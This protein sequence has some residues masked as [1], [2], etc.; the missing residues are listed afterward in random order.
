MNGMP[1]KNYDEFKE[2]FVREDGKRK[3]KV[4]LD[5][6]KSR[7]V[8]SFIVNRGYSSQFCA[9]TSMAQLKAYVSQLIRATRHF[10]PIV[11]IMGDPY[12]TPEFES[13]GN[14]GICED[15][16]FTCYRYY[17][18]TRGGVYKMRIGKLFRIAMLNSDFGRVLPE[19]IIL[20]M[21]EEISRDWI[22]YAQ[23]RLPGY[24]LVVDDDFEAIYNRDMYENRADFQSCMTSQEQHYFYE[25]SVDAKAA[26]I[27]NPET[28]NIL[29][30][31]VIYMDARDHA[32][33]KYRLAERQYSKYGDEVLKS[34]LVYA[35]I[36]GGYIDGYK[37]VGADCHNAKAWL[38][39]THKPI[40]NNEF[41]I[42][43]NLE[44]DDILS[45]QDSFKWYDRNT[46]TAYNYAY[47]A[48]THMLDTTDSR[49]EGENYDSWHEEYT[50]CD[51]VPVYY[52]G[53]EYYCSE[54]RLDD[55]YYIESLDEYHHYSD[56]SRCPICGERMV[57]G[58]GEL[59]DLTGNE[60]CCEDCIEVA[61][62]NYKEEYWDYSD[63]ECAYIDPD[64]SVTYYDEDGE[65]YVTMGYAEDMVRSGRAIE[66]DGEFY[67]IDLEYTEAE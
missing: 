15:G 14:A 18:R 49:L 30:R 55:F 61:E 4:L 25:R 3:N 42:R 28:G 20:W 6:L 59:S 44:V 31:C 35:L 63:I 48:Y 38:D 21:C 64:D 10:G 43:C 58:R 1:F 27:R 12:S 47:H 13:D 67:S 9:P 40:E 16:D 36:N 66:R 8:R 26:S 53:V 56:V 65:H 57:S 5:Y 50:D 39:A 24:E 29:A 37:K 51:I 54:D 22:A 23:T 33:N 17:N 34:V 11:W 32:G 41:S 2:L 45:Y 7:E 62:K 52:E 46:H 60:Y 19:S